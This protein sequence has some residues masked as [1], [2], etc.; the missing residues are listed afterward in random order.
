MSQ[1]AQQEMNFAASQLRES[2]LRLSCTA[3]AL[4]M[5]GQMRAL[6]VPAM[7][8]GLNDAAKIEAITSPLSSGA[9][10]AEAIGEAMVRGFRVPPVVA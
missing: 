7:K 6:D 10:L 9:Q 1:V 5:A 3:D 2:A 4:G 8:E